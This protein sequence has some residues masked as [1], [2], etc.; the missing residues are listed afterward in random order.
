MKLS[1]ITI[2]FALLISSV[3]FVNPSIA[4]SE[5]TLDASGF[6]NKTFKISAYYSPLPC[7]DRYA[8]GSY[9]GDIRLN[10]NGTNGADGTPVYP[11]M[12]AAPKTYAFGTKMNIP[13]IG[14]VAVHDRGGA[15]V[16]SNSAGVYDR[17]DVWMGYGDVGLKRALNWGKRDVDV[18]M[19]G[20]TDEVEEQ[21]SLMGFSAEESVPNCGGGEVTE[22]V[23]EEA[24]EIEEASPVIFTDESPN[25]HTSDEEDVLSVGSTGSD[26]VALQEELRRLNFLRIDPTGYYGE[27][28]EHAVFKFQQS[29]GLVAS[30]DEEWA[31]IYGPVTREKMQTFVIARSEREKMIAQA[32]SRTESTEEIVAVMTSDTPI[33][34]KELEPGVNDDEVIVLQQFLMEG[35][36]FENPGVTNFYGSLTR[37]AVIRFQ[38][39]NGLIESESDTGAGRVGPSTLRAINTQS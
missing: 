2:S 21:V 33:L 20:V 26:V 28:T 15:I 11:G 25:V 37:E 14:I 35:G 32:S 38:I 34:T 13:G 3:A 17:L 9:E 19:Y 24:P 23:V 5:D 7:Q 27:V 12:I 29:Q 39:A 6:S 22:E 1:R 8:T 16:A 4:I 31:G 10:G 36:Y 18:V 30:V